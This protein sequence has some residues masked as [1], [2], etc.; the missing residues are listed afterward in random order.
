HGGQGREFLRKQGEG[1]GGVT[2][3]TPLTRPSPKGRG[4]DRTR[5]TVPSPCGRRLWSGAFSVGV[6]SCKESTMS[7]AV[8]LEVKDQI[9]HVILNRPDAFNSLNPD[10]W[11]EFP[12]AF[13]EIE[14]RGDVRV[15]VLSSTGKHFCAGLD[16]N[17]FKSLNAPSDEDE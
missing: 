15:V 9:A 7:K 8:K 3:T 1:G 4:F 14:A 16:L 10:F 12:A 5:H 11:V 2:E 17:A 13:E 6:S